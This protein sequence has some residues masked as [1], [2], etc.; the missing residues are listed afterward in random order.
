VWF[1]FLWHI[2]A[3]YLRDASADPREAFTYGWKS[4]HLDTVAV[5]NVGASPKTILEA[6]GLGAKYPSLL[7]RETLPNDVNYKLSPKIG[8][9]PKRF[10]E[11]Q[12]SKFSAKFSVFSE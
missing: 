12:N 2:A 9:P 10:G 7:R 4:G 1:I 3:L 11:S 8:V 5:P 6:N